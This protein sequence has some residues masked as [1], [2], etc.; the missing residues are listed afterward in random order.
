MAPHKG[1]ERPA[2]PTAAEARACHGKVK[3]PNKR[4][5]HARARQLFV[6]GE[7]YRCRLCGKWHIS[8]RR[9]ARTPRALGQGD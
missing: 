7:A 2:G 9:S 6:R 3:L 8:S 5:A 1:Y 4:T